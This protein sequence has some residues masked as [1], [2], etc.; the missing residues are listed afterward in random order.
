MD[1][2]ESRVIGLKRKSDSQVEILIVDDDEPLRRLLG[3]LLES[4]GYKC[5]LACDADEARSH[6][7][8]RVFHLALCDIRLPH[9]SGLN[10]AKTIADRHPETAIL[11]ISAIN[12]PEVAEIA[13]EFG[14]YGYLT[15]PVKPID[16]ILHVTNALRRRK[17]EIEN[18]LH[19]EAL[20]R[21]VQERTK[22]LEETLQNLRKVL[23]GII[24]AIA[25][26]VE[27][28]DPYTAGHQQRVA[29]LAHSVATEMV[30]SKDRTDGI[31]LAAIIHDIGK[32]AVPAEILS[33]PIRLTTYEY[34]IIKTHPQV[35]FDI[36]KNIDFPWPIAQIIL[37]HHERLNGSGYPQ[38]LQGKDILVEA[39]ILAVADVVEA[40]SSHRPY[41][42]ALGLDKAIEEIS[43]NK[44]VLYDPEPVDVCV[45]LLT[46][47]GFKFK[48]YRGEAPPSS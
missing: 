24:N 26:I 25:L 31:R 29:D 14:S 30:I 34:Q 6:L 3:Q 2:N 16:I 47:K 40:I 43:L 48:N 12:D 10:L 7:E 19:N 8:S 15:K 41:R 22:S 38:G 21:M 45:D 9:E 20:Q 4:K 27:S 23:G 28:R 44:N 32:I 11:M 42:P 36:L 35:G 37:Q 18:R 1:G 39:Q 17:L 46:K 33:K 5:S 13:L